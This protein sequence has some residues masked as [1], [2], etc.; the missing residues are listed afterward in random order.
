MELNYY[1]YIDKD[2]KKKFLTEEEKRKLIEKRKLEEQEIKKLEKLTKDL[3]LFLLNPL[4]WHNQK[5]F[6]KEK[7][8]LEEELFIINSVAKIKE[9]LLLKKDTEIV[10]TGKQQRYAEKIMK[11]LKAEGIDLQHSLKN[12]PENKNLSSWSKK[13]E[14]EREDKGRDNPLVN[15]LSMERK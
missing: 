14:K 6:E 12:L 13:I 15:S 1:Y 11:R 4:V 3:I 7:R 9:Q 2:G 5:D 8:R 10:L